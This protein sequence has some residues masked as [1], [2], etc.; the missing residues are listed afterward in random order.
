MKENK[1]TD[2]SNVIS[3]YLKALKVEDVDKLRGLMDSIING[4]AIPKKE[5]KE[6]MVKLL[7][8]GGRREEMQRNYLPI[9]LISVI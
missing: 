1:T 7:H 3:E 5:W 8:K 2:E 6:S 9:A 4:A